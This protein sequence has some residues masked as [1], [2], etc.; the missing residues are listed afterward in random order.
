ME[1]YAGPSSSL[2]LAI[3]IGVLWYFTVFFNL[4]FPKDRWC[5]VSFHVLIYHLYIFIVKSITDNL[6]EMRS[7]YWVLRVLC[8]P[9]ASLISYM[10]CTYVLPVYFHSLNCSFEEQKFVLVKSKLSVC[11]FRD[12]AFGLV[13]TKSFLRLSSQRFSPLF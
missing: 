13:S 7:H 8:V 3:L 6:F 4:H 2:I 9:D 5:W 11:F 10:S 12:H 1:K